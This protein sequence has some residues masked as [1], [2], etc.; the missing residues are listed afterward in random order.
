MYGTPSA[1]SMSATASLVHSARALA[2]NPLPTWVADGAAAAEE[3][4]R[5]YGSVADHLRRVRPDVM[6]FFTADHYN[7]FFESCVPIFSIGVAESAAGASD[8][9]ELRGR[10]V[11]TAAELARDVHAETVR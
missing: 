2:F 11:P 10:V 1:R 6:V 8:S 7:I 4:E 9:P 3:I 5:M